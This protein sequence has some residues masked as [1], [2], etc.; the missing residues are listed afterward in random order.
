[1]NIIQLNNRLPY[2]LKLKEKT[3]ELRKNMTEPEKK[4]WFGF[5]RNIS[6]SKFRVYRQR[7]INNFIVD[8]YIP[9]LKIVIEVDGETHFDEAGIAYDEE[10]TQ[11][12]EGLGLKVLRF[13]NKDIMENFDVV[14]RE[15]EKE[16]GIN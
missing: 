1:M 5:L 10:R 3:K 8:F 4:I 13:T 14:C 6:N 7:P 11:I 12:L 16:L 15:L 2:N 9:K